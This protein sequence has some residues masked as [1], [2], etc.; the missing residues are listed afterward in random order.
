[1]IGSVDIAVSRAAQVVSNVKRFV[2]SDVSAPT[3]QT[4][5]D[6]AENIN[7][8]L[9]VFRHE[10]AK[11]VQLDVNLSPGLAIMGY[12]VRLFQLWSNIIKNAIDAVESKPIKKITVQSYVQDNKV[13]V[14]IANN[15]EMIPTEIREK[16]FDKF[17]STKRERNGTGLGLAIV[18][19]VLNEHNAKISLTS[20]HNITNFTITFP[21]PL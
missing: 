18:M 10:F 12:D 4:K 21:S 14:S 17:Y 7:V 16:I 6:L 20:D 5:V 19:S 13:C 9:G 8:V 2:R 1:M 15:G 3:L 11:N